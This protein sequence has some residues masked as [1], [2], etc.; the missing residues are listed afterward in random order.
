MARK[1]ILSKIISRRTDTPQKKVEAAAAGAPRPILTLMFFIIDWQ[2]S[3]IISDIFTEEDVRFYFVTKGVGTANSEI[4]DLLGIGAGEKAVALCLE[5]P[6]LVPVLLKEVRKK[7]GFYT[8]GTG[9]AFTVPLS[10][11]NDPVLL[12]FKQ[13]IL[14]NVKIAEEL[15]ERAQS[16]RPPKGENM[17]SDNT[18]REKFKFDLIFA[19]VNHGYSDEFMITAREAGASGGTVI[20]A[21]GQAHEGAVK[22]FGISVQDEKEIILILT[23]HE[24]KVAIMQAVS[25]THGLN[26][27]AGGIVF[28][29][30]VDNVIG[31][32]FE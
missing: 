19:I 17:E 3:H 1:T 13:S 31:P 27:K 26:S 32:S 28:S 11:I 14:K 15:E 9:I 7:L 29:V 25:E 20:N 21:R 12:V 5:Q 18:S 2:K 6:V 24:K 23:T 16:S 22:F 30:P 4:L 10:A 8:P